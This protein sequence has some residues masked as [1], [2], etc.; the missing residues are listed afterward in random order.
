MQFVGSDIINEILRGSIVLCNINEPGQKP[1]GRGPGGKWKKSWWS[2]PLDSNMR[3]EG[4]QQAD[5]AFEQGSNRMGLNGPVL[6]ASSSSSTVMPLASPVDISTNISPT[7]PSIS[8]MPVGASLS[9]ATVIP[10][11]DWATAVSNHGYH[12]HQRHAHGHTNH[13][14]ETTLYSTDSGETLE[15]RHDSTLANEPFAYT[16]TQSAHQHG[17]AYRQTSGPHHWAPS[18]DS[19]F[20][21]SAAEQAGATA[22]WQDDS[23]R[24][25]RLNSQTDMLQSSGSVNH[26]GLVSPANVGYPTP[27]SEVGASGSCGS[28]LSSTFDL[29]DSVTESPNQRRRYNGMISSHESQSRPHTSSGS[30][31][32]WTHSQS[33]YPLQHSTWLGDGTHLYHSSQ[34]EASMSSINTLSICASEGPST[35]PSFN[36]GSQV[37][38]YHADAAPLAGLSEGV[39]HLSLDE[40]GD[41]HYSK[42]LLT[43]ERSCRKLL[44]NHVLCTWLSFSRSLQRP[45]L[46]I[47]AFDV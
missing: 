30:A 44:L 11:G 41:L 42:F 45:A 8:D 40:H 23:C 29:I 9:A 18:V 1:G 3:R 38:N 24:L 16:D 26:Q 28:Q 37:R 39:G 27:H 35:T 10:T 4:A 20:E 43:F 13:T 12:D 5:G 33:A 46:H 22:S 2:A 19:R 7:F 6:N 21:P 17:S 32:S 47:E 15:Q 31:S 34:P 25:P 36:P 14:Q